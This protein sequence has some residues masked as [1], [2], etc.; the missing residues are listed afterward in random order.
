[1]PTLCNAV[2]SIFGD[3][4]WGLLIDKSCSVQMRGKIGYSVAGSDDIISDMPMEQLMMIMS[5]ARFASNDDECVSVAKMIYWLINK[6]DALPMV[7]CHYGFDLAARCLISISLFRKAIEWRTR[8]RGSP[9]VTFYRE[10]GIRTSNDIGMPEIA[11][12]F[13]N[14]SGFIGETIGS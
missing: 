10:V 14:W 1:M 6:P 13:D 12:H 8:L 3:A 9:P 4:A 2:K 5:A 7:H 11:T